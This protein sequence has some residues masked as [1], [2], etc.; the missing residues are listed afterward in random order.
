MH[1]PSTL[2]HY[3]LQTHRLCHLG[4]DLDDAYQ[5]Q[6]VLSF[7]IQRRGPLQKN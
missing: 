2:V 6:H 3:K 7:V 1:K 4:S 5:M